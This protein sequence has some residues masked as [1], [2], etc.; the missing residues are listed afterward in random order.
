MSDTDCS[1][2]DGK[3]KG[4]GI[5]SLSEE[6]LGG[7]IREGELVGVVTPCNGQCGVLMLFVSAWLCCP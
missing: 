1:L 6:Y 2:D 7:E 3:G 5:Q 4:N